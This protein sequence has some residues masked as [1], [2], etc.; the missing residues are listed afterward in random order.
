MQGTLTRQVEEYL[1][2]FGMFQLPE[3]PGQAITTKRGGHIYLDEREGEFTT[4]IVRRD[5]STLEDV[6]PVAEPGELAIAIRALVFKAR[7]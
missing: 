1:R 2:P 6:R 7:A 3:T 5:G 4:R